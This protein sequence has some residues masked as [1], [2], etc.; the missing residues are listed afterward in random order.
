MFLGQ[1]TNGKKGGRPPLLDDQ[2]ITEATEEVRKRSI[3]GEGFARPNSFVDFIRKYARDTLRRAGHLNADFVRITISDRKKRSLHLQFV[4]EILQN[5][6]KI[7]RSRFLSRINLAVSM[8]S[9]A[10]LYVALKGDGP[11][12]K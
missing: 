5:S 7:N 2:A 1:P 11:D 12:G 8:A 10:V 6:D 4:P 3:S 9:A